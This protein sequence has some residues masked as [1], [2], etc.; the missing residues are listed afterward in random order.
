MVGGLTSYA[1]DKRFWLQ[2][3]PFKNLIDW[4]NFNDQNKIYY[5]ILIIF[6]NW[7]LVDRESVKKNYDFIF[8]GYLFH[9]GESA[10]DNWQGK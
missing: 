4:G 2:K 3:A 5:K 7:V 6:V 8:I 1:I 10:K 9:V